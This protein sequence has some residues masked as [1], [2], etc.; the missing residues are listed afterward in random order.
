MQ[1]PRLSASMSHDVWRKRAMVRSSTGTQIQ[2]L[3]ED[4]ETVP[5]FGVTNSKM[6]APQMRKV[7]TCIDHTHTGIMYLNLGLEWSSTIIANDDRTT[8]IVYLTGSW[9]F[10]PDVTHS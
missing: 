10:D 9:L 5:T 7:R 2:L 3:S 6:N 8:V 4:S 1:P